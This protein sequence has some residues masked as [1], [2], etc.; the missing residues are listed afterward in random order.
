MAD[1]LAN[2]A[3]LS[4][5]EL[6]QRKEEMKRR[7]KLQLADYDQLTKQ[8]IEQAQK[9]LVPC[10]EVG[11]GKYMYNCKYYCHVTIIM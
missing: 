7:H 4:A 5:Q 1:L 9:D 3:G 11:V 2:S 10:L 6:N 8:L